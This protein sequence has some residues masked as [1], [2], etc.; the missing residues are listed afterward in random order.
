MLAAKKDRLLVFSFYFLTAVAMT[1]P[2][3]TR[4][5]SHIPAGGFDLWQNYWNLWWW[6]EALSQGRSPYSTDLLLVPGE[7]PLGLHTH[8]PANM[9][10]TLPINALFGVSAALNLAIFASFVLAAY[11]AFLLAKEYTSSTSAALLTGI[12]FAFFPQHTEQA[13]EHL[14]LATYQAMP[15]FLWALVRTVRQGGRWWLATGALFAVNALFAWHHALLVVPMALAVVVF[16]SWRGS[17]GLPRVV[18]DLVRAAAIALVLLAPFL[19]PIVRD[20]QA[21]VAV[22]QKGFPDRAI[23]PILLLLPHYGHPIWGSTLGSLHTGLRSYRAVGGL[24]YLGLVTLV[25]SICAILKRRPNRPERDP[26]GPSIPRGSAGF[27]AMLFVFFTFLSLGSILDTGSD[28]GTNG[29]PMPFF[30]LRHFPLLG[31]IRVPNRFL[32]PAML[33][34]AT[35]AATGVDRLLERVRPSLHRPLIA[36]L[37]VLM[38]V[39]YAWLP[40]PMRELTPPQWIA[41]LE[42][43]PADLTVMDIPSGY[44]SWGAI[45]MYL[46]TLHGRP[47]STGYL[48]TTPRKVHDRF[49]TYPALQDVFL[50]FERRETA[51]PAPNLVD[52]IRDLGIGVV[53]V[54]LDRTS[55]SVREQGRLARKHHPDDLVV[56]RLYPASK[57]IPAADLADIR[58]Q[59]W[60]AFGTPIHATE[61]I[62]IYLVR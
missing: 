34:L 32:I 9:L 60:V 23:N 31:L 33:A 53:L 21:D 27:W 54:H 29:L 20:L 62:E 37:L 38:L 49:R 44:R 2:L 40:F 5:T 16:E 48:S 1:W 42:K 25:L 56:R 55:E 43:L 24:G 4:L 61:E 52:T 15:F 36:A 51:V 7:T 41:E 35:L 47:T 59:I 58:D 22:L 45:D 46:Q 3:L 13:L 18:L 57:A 19:W 12:A 8:S 10:W 30:W 14:N 26:A 17:R 6:K 50:P 39:D 11:G 28:S